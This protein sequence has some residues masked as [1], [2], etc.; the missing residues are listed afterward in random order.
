MKHLY[1]TAVLAVSMLGAA[2]GQAR[3]ATK[4]AAKAAAKPAAKPAAAPA[5]AV[6]EAPADQE[7][8]QYAG[9]YL[10]GKRVSEIDCYGMDEYTI[11]YPYLAPLDICNYFVVGLRAG[12]L[13]NKGE[14]VNELREYTTYSDG[15]A[16]AVR[17]KYANKG[18]G[19]ITRSGL[20]ERFN[21]HRE[22]RPGEGYVAEA[23]L[24]SLNLLKYTDYDP[25]KYSGSVLY[26]EIYTYTHSGRFTDRGE[27]IFTSTKIY[28]SAP[29]ALKNRV[30]TGTAGLKDS[31]ARKGLSFVPIV[32]AVAMAATKGKPLPEMT[33]E[34]CE[35][36]GTA[37]SMTAIKKVGRDDI[38]EEV[39]TK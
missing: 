2:H 31:N 1:L 7:A 19:V 17:A 26:V 35:Y 24:P 10:N 14:F 33:A 28:T 30:S 9:L 16:D 11:V 39:L 21:A 4:P 32:G 29:I 15:D 37:V 6:E 34:A 5:A 20:L 23:N 25:G 22:Y 18:Y 27:A 12:S 13:N 36:P 8:P 3:P 38:G